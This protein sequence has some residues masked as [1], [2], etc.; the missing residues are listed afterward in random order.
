LERKTDFFIG[1]QKGSAE[2]IVIEKFHE[3]EKR[4][5]EVIDIVFYSYICAS[6]D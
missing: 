5:S 4:A 3:Y 6:V 1:A 2:K